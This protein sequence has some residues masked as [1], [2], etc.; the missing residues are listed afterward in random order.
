MTFRQ[1][2]RTR[3][4][5]RPPEQAT[6][7][8]PKQAARAEPGPDAAPTVEGIALRSGP[9]RGAV[10]AEQTVQTPLDNEVR[11]KRTRSR[12]TRKPGTLVD[13]DPD[14]PSYEPPARRGAPHGD[15]I[16][17]V[18]QRIADGER[19]G[20]FRCD[21]VT[22]TLVVMLFRQV[23]LATGAPHGYCL[24]P[25][26]GDDELANAFGWG[27]DRLRW[28]H[29]P[30]LFP[31]QPVWRPR[32]LRAW[33]ELWHGVDML[34]RYGQL[35]NDVVAATFQFAAYTTGKQ[36]D[37]G[38]YYTPFSVCLLMATVV[39]GDEPWNKSLMEPCVGAGSMVVAMWEVVRQK[40]I[41]A[42]RAGRITGDEAQALVRKWVAGVKATDIDAEAAWAASAQLAVRTGCPVRGTAH[43]YRF[44]EARDGVAGGGSARIRRGHRHDDLLT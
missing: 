38:A 8:A 40:L 10:G 28:I 16:D 24:N 23:E 18:S 42:Q 27:L 1:R 17:A 22:H 31:E 3:R 32:H 30:A 35:T 15:R 9:H 36:K 33:V 12:Q 5:M 20:E 39:A 11:A 19:R 25:R 26:Q 41:D 4:A 2:R 7:E 34:G 43:P 13:V 44:N 29:G 37:W 14:E 21:A 6:K